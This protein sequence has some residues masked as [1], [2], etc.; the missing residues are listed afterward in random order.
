VKLCDEHAAKQRQVRQQK[1]VQRGWRKARG[2]DAEWQKLRSW[3]LN[4]HPLCECD[5]CQAGILKVTAAEVVDHI[6][7]I[8]QAPHLRLEPTNLRAMSKS[9]HD[10][11]TAKT[12][13]WAGNIR[14]R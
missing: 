9:C 11:H 1:D 14:G 3:F 8:Q 5:D 12:T 13:G 7:P 10:R 2:Y 6:V 4:R